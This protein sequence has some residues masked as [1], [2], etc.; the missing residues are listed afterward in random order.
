MKKPL[1]GLSMMAEADFVSAIL[2][3]FENNQIEILEW[4]FDTF[5]DVEEPEWLKG[6]LDF[7]SQ[8]NRLIGHGVYYSLF[9]AKW[10][11][12]QEEWLNNLK[13]ETEKRHYNHITEHFGFM[14][15]ENFHQGIPLPVSLNS[16]TLQIGKDRLLRLQDV[17]NVPIGIENLAFSFSI[18]DVKQQGQFLDQL[19]TDID[20][21]LILDLHNIYCQAYN[22]D[23]QLEEIISA[24]PLEKVKE[25]HL[26]G[27]SWNQSIY[28]KNKLIRRDTHDDAIPEEI[29]NILPFVLPKCENLQYIIIE[30]LGCTIKTKDE[31][32]AFFD[33]FRRVREIIDSIEYHENNYPAIWEK[34][35]VNLVSPLEDLQLYEDQTRLTQLLFDDKPELIKSQTFHYFKT[36]DWDIEMINTAKSIIKKWNPY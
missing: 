11:E 27:G 19:I 6:L 30:R 3:L 9:D 33:D 32:E 12:R 13:T 8:N 18:E 1:L 22:F 31:K 34:K 16:K 7:Y 2:P 28:T 4:S 23:V 35:N 15:T 20:G 36:D 14:N 24:Y 21:F 5:Y 10:T 26:S 29:L 25:I 17:V